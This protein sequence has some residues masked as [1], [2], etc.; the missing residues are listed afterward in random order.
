VKLIVATGNKHKLDEISAAMT[1]CG[2]EIISMR[3]AGFK[4]HLPEENAND[5]EGNA[6]IKAEAVAE[7]LNEQAIA[8]D[9][10]LVVDALDGRPGV[11][12]ARYAGPE[13]D[14]AANNARLL[15]EMADVPADKRTARFVCVIALA[16][17]GRE[18]LFFRGEAEGIILTEHRGEGGFGYDP[19]FYSPEL[20][21]TFAEN[22]AGKPRVS[23]RGRALAKLVE[24]IK[25]EKQHA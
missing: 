20:G 7:M 17:P 25:Q 2:V 1:D 13:A 16:R 21:C 6:A 11:K 12:S 19:L 24:F 14:Y 10:G 4:G 22:A 23:H 15:W 8:D 3:E 9:S 5:F 18:T